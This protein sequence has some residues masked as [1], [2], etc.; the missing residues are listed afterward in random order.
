[1]KCEIR[2][3]QDIQLT[4]DFDEEQREALIDLLKPAMEPDEEVERLLDESARR[5]REIESEMWLYFEAHPTRDQLGNIITEET[6]E[7]GFD[8]VY[9]EQT[10][11]GYAENMYV[12]P[13][14]SEYDYGDN[15]NTR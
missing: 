5:R 7:I 10:G 13:K 2:R 15:T 4:F 12:R 9:D 14:K 6:H 3:N 8:V 1:M 11:L